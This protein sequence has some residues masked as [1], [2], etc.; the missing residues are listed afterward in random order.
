[1]D[2]L[3]KYDTLSDQSSSRMINNIPQELHRR[4]G[5]QWSATRAT[6]CFVFKTS[7]WW[8]YFIECIWL[9]YP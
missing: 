5:A 3:Q 4:D 6:L 2:K 8:F 7:I 9:V 1:M